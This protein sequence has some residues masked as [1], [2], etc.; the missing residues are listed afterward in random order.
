MVKLREF[1]EKNTQFE[2]IGRTFPY[3]DMIAWILAHV[4]IPTR[5]V[6]D[7]NKNVLTSSKPYILTTISKLSSPKFLFTTQF[8]DHFNNT[9]LKQSGK[10]YNKFI[11]DWF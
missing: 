5:L 7:C 10:D 8:L 4:D 9:S 3:Y 1:K 6:L 2:N 11:E